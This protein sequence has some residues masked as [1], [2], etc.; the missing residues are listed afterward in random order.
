MK[1]VINS[2]RDNKRK[3]FGIP[4]DGPTNRQTDKPTDISKTIN[5][6]FFEDGGIITGQ[7]IH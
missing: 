4:T 7:H 3:T 6:H 5:T 2:F 1:A